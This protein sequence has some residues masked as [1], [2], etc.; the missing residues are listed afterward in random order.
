MKLCAVR[1]IIIVLFLLT[2]NHR[3]Y[4]DTAP[5]KYDKKRELTMI[6]STEKKYMI[7]FMLDLI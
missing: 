4:S 3:D 5:V 2:K 1:T 7:H 6:K